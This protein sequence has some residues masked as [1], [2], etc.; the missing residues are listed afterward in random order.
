[1]VLVLVAVAGPELTLAAM[2]AGIRDV[3]PPDTETGQMREAL[4]RATGA[5]RSRRQATF[6]DAGLQQTRAR[7]NLRHVPQRRGGGRRLLPPI[8]LLDWPSW[9]RWGWS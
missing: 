6:G 4:D 1:M 7:G 2:R 5:A 8:W 3:L 9:R